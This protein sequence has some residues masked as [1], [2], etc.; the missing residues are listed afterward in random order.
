MMGSSIGLGRAVVS[1]VAIKDN[2]ALLKDLAGGAQVMAVVKANAYGHG[3][4]PAARAAMA[5]GATHLGVARLEEALELSRQLGPD[6]PPI[7][8]W[9]Y[10]H[11]AP[12][13][14]AVDR[15]IEIGV[16][17]VAAL[18]VVVRAARRVGQAARVHLKFDSGLGRG[19]A[20]AFDWPALV[21]AGLAA[22]AE[23]AVE[24]AGMW[25][26]FAYADEPG[27]PTVLAQELAFRD[28]LALAGRL[29]AQFEVVHL[30]NSAALLTGRPVTYDL[31]RP[32]LA[33]YGLSP[34][35][36]RAGPAEL[37]LTPAMTLEADLTLVKRLPAGHG[38][39]YGH[40]YV[41][42]SETT[43]GLVSLGYADG[44][45]RTASGRASVQVAG[46]R[47][48]MA[49]RVCMDQFMVD[50][51][52]DATEREGERVVLFGPGWDGEPTAQDWAEAAG[53]I[54]YEVVTRIPAH[55]P[56]VYQGSEKL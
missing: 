56:R 28:A 29:G 12:L 43:I 16:S 52:P 8:T 45:F 27:H 41:T 37:G 15:S 35:P 3:L 21:K 36:D 30:A 4:E 50:L 44:I 13:S 42:K 46:R 39:S 18:A 25:S 11:E 24:L 48:P 9:I 17:S 7:L 22:R 32:G 47:I 34:I 53:T 51:G 38:V 14:L 19:G 49:G 54:S 1:L 40:I 55:V 6:G 10:S 23:G 31:V 2:T 20:T 5:G 26:H 33:I